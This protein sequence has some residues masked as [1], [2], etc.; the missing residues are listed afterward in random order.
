MFEKN[1]KDFKRVQITIEITGNTG[2]LKVLMGQCHN[3]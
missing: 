2:G 3:I 1:T